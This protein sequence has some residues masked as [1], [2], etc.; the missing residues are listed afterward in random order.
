MEGESYAG[1]YVPILGHAIYKNKDNA[2]PSYRINLKGVAIGN[3]VSDPV[4]QIGFGEYFYQLGYI[5]LSDRNVF[6]QYQN[7]AINLIKQG[8]FL[9]ALT[10]TFGLIN[11]KYCLFNNLTGF[12]SAYNFAR[13]DG[14]NPT[15]DRVSAY[16][17]NPNGIKKCL[18]VG[19]R[20]FAAFTETN[21]VLQ[22]LANDIL[23]TVAPYVAELANNYDVFIYTGQNDLLVNVVGTENYLSKLNYNGVNDLVSAKRSKWYVDNEIAGWFVKGGRLSYA[24]VHNAGHMVPYDVPKIAY[25][26][27]RRLTTGKLF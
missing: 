23:D 14:Y 27:L 12:E 4:N 20:Q 13:F 7:L 17:T 3:G 10:Y 21:P 6:N 9:N 25:D 19:T 2:D 1:K 11:T 8:Q 18:N 22:N 15:V 26:L 16:L 5:S 24:I